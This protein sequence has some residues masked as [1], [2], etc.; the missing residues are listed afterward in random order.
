MK[1][2]CAGHAAA[3]ILLAATVTSAAPTPSFL[4]A[5]RRLVAKDNAKWHLASDSGERA[6]GVLLTQQYEAGNQTSPKKPSFFANEG[7]AAGQGGA[8]RKGGKKQGES[9]HPK[10]WW[11][12][13]DADCDEVCDPVCAPP[14]CETACGSINLATCTQKCDPPKCAIVCPSM[15]CE[16]G[17]CP[18]CKTVCGPPKCETICSEQCESKC[19]EPQ[20]SWKCTPGQCEKPR[21]SLTCGGAKMCDFNS[22]NGGRPPWKDSMHVVSQGLAAFD[23]KTLGIESP[24][25][26]PAAAPPPAQAQAQQGS[27]PAPSSPNSPM[28]R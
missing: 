12:C 14:Q 26:P 11:T 19:S 17:D 24:A 25:S 15:H 28:V 5:A 8:A 2:V 7:G 3:A 1:F 20:C 18:Q 16:H 9:C 27:A 13:G 23:P 21:C 10:C 6:Q 4:T 22:Q